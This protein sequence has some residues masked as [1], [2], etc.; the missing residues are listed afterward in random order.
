MSNRWFRFVLAVLALTAAAAAGYRIYQQE[1]VLASEVTARHAG[2]AGAEAALTTVSELKAALHAYVAPGQGTGFWTARAGM[3]LERLRSALLELDGAVTAAGG[4]T[5][6]ALEIVDKLAAA[7]RRARDHA[8]AEQALLAGEV[9]FT[10]A[11]DLLDA[12]RLEVA[13]ARGEMTAAAG[14]REA[15]M[16]R[17]QALLALG[18]AGVLA[19]AMLLLVIP[20]RGVT[21]EPAVAAATETPTPA[22]ER[23]DYQSTARVISRVPLAPDSQAATAVPPAARA[24]APR[25]QPQ[26][27]ST[28]PARTAGAPA[29]PAGPPPP[30]GA[31]APASQ[32]SLALIRDAA[33]V[34]TDLGR[35]SQSLEISALLDR[36]AKVLDASG[37]VIWMSSAD[38]H[39]LYPAAAAGYDEQLLARIGAIARDSANV[40]A[41]AFRDGAARSSPADTDSRAALAVP[42]VGPSGPVGVLSAEAR[43]GAAF[44]DTRVALATIFAAQLALLLGSIGEAGDAS[45]DGVRSANL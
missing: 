4:S 41:G 31:A 20:G 26:G 36:A 15:A 24:G 9:I 37:V 35:V 22:I 16:R 42:L 34:C 5:G 25:S 11:R 1:Q 19:F 38:G 14:S 17:E 30:A 13:R 28:P 21:A 10:E 3:L 39:E 40:T 6:E 7:E 2:D 23:D 12:L 33:A 44:D 32:T 43:E 8:R 29:A 18:A 27:R 45:A